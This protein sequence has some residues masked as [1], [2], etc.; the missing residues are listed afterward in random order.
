MA[1]ERTVNCR[2]EGLTPLLMH[3]FADDSIPDKIKKSTGRPE[4]E[5]DTYKA[6]YVNE[7][8]KLVQPAIHL[9][10]CMTAGGID[11]KIPGKRGRNY[12]KLIGSMV[13]VE[14]DYILHE[15]QEWKQDCQPV[16][17][18]KARIHRYRPRLDKWAL[19]FQIVIEDDQIPLDALKQIM[20]HAGLY[21]GIGDFRPGTKGKYG[22]FQVTR[23]EQ[24]NGK[25][26]H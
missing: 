1:K 15:H 16:R 5:E 21:V 12:S 11:F 14:P 8:G 26:T 4:Y 25:G 10:R 23:W 18:Q 24:V 17:I 6:L 13:R 7:K 2:I 22:K 3:R 20:D 9:E 19:D